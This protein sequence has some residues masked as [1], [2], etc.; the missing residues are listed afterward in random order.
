[1]LTEPPKGIAGIL[2]AFPGRHAVARFETVIGPC[3]H[4]PSA[5]EIPRLW[6]ECP[7][8]AVLPAA[9]EEEHNAG[10]LVR[11]FPIGRKMNDHFQVSLRR[12]GV[13]EGLGGLLRTNR[14]WLKKRHDRRKHGPEVPHRT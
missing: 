6:L 5:G 9:A 14:T 3:R 11:C 8:R 12:L 4:H 10:P 1:M 2:H 13:D 7:D